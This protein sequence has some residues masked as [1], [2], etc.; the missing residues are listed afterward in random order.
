MT[1]M[2]NSIKKQQQINQKSQAQLNALINSANKKNYSNS[3]S[4][5]SQNT[6]SQNDYNKKYEQ[7]KRELEKQKIEEQSKKQKE[8]KLK[9]REEEIKKKKLQRERLK[10]EKELKRKEEKQRK[11]REKQQ[12]LTKLKNTIKLAAKNCYGE[13]H[14]GGIIPKYSPR[15]VSCIDVSFMATC[16]NDY[17]QRA[18]GVMETMVS[19]AG[20]CFGDTKQVSPKL[21]CKAEDY[22][23]KVT[24][25]T[26]CK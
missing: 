8:L 13:H 23:V 12:Y 19:N 2:N 9:K 1:S 16:K 17:T 14:V 24:N 11:E 26:S 21:G 18:K 5:K 20:G 15:P 6:Y 22:V 4:Y 10:K 7:K 25:V 3:S